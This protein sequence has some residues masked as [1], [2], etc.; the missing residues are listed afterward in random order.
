[1]ATYRKKR[2][3]SKSGNRVVRRKSKARKIQ[4]AKK[5]S[6]KNR[7]STHDPDKISTKKYSG[8]MGKKRSS[9]KK[10]KKKSPL[11][12]ESRVKQLLHSADT[13]PKR[14]SGLLFE[15]GGTGG[16]G[17]QVIMSSTANDHCARQIIFPNLEEEQRTSEPFLQTVTGGYPYQVG[18]GIG[19][20][21]NLK[22]RLSGEIWFAP[23]L[24][25]S[26]QKTGKFRVVAGLIQKNSA[27][28]GLPSTPA[29]ADTFRT[30]F[31]GS[32]YDLHRIDDAWYNV[33]SDRRPFPFNTTGP[34][35][36][37]DR[38]A[39][40]NKYDPNWN[41]SGLANLFRDR[42]LFKKTYDEV[43]NFSD[44]GASKSYTGSYPSGPT[45]RREKLDMTFDFGLQKLNV[46]ESGTVANL[47]EFQDAQPVIMIY[48]SYIDDITPYVNVDD[49]MA[50][51]DEEQV[52]FTILDSSLAAKIS[53]NGTM[54]LFGDTVNAAPL[55]FQTT[56]DMGLSWRE[57]ETQ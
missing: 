9:V 13:V 54:D 49:D 20:I 53:A 56:W 30:T 45:G 22:V 35:D 2:S 55:F 5:Y 39:G 23:N 14:I 28:T 24:N 31:N 3:S 32:A 43:F 29:T 38:K 17:Q 46:N 51:R 26:K 41:G 21:K 33:Q 25:F 4:T 57:E 16:N 19:H 34:S 27:T 8:R 36:E 50:V 6:K 48:H 40:M 42:S 10:G 52:P 37:I 44:F 7:F 12:T 15:A 47:M 1:M 11:V 18:S